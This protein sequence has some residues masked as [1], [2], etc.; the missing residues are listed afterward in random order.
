MNKKDKT[1]KLT[2]K[3]FYLLKIFGPYWH[4]IR[5]TKKL[6]LYLE[7]LN[8]ELNQNKINLGTEE[9]EHK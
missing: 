4:S 6:I 1:I 7:F 3:E 2:V 8:K 9:T 5:D